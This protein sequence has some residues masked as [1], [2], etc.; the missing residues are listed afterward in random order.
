MR[1]QQIIQ[2]YEKEL[3]KLKKELEKEVSQITI[4]RN[5]T[6][7]ALSSFMHN[8]VNVEVVA[9]RLDVGEADQL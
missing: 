8:V 5:R 4:T 3:E 1:K 6:G 2:G 7:L 9:D